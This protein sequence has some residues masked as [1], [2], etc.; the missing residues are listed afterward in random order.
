MRKIVP[1]SFSDHITGPKFIPPN[2]EIQQALMLYIL[3]T[4]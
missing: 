3:F 1:Y 2:L 4:F